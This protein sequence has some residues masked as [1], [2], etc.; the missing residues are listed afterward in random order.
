VPGM[1]LAGGLFWSKAAPHVSRA[2]AQ[3]SAQRLLQLGGRAGGA[4]S[5]G[6][7]ECDP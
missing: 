1:A 3:G 6:Y 5:D 2:S 4:P 7:P